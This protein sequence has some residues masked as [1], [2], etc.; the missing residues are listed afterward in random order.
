MRE[1]TTNQD[2][3]PLK[4]YKKPSKKVDI[5]SILYKLMKNCQLKGK[6]RLRERFNYLTSP[7]LKAINYKKK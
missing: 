2:F 6:Y 5:S 3:S 1:L 4:P 7:Q